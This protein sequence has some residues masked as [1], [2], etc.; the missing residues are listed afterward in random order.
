MYSICCLFLMQNNPKKTKGPTT[1]GECVCSFTF[2]I[3]Q[4]LI[5]MYLQLAGTT[6]FCLILVFWGT[7]S[8]FYTILLCSSNHIFSPLL[9]DNS[10]GCTCLVEGK[11]KGKCL[12]LSDSVNFTPESNPPIPFWTAFWQYL[13][14]EAN[15]H[16]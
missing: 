2:V 9:A 12:F 16:L 14:K 15:W 4:I 5:W 10:P 8:S 13:S 1:K 7:E 6:W 3:R 11:F